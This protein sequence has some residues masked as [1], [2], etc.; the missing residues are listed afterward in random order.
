LALLLIFL[1][2]GQRIEAWLRGLGPWAQVLL[3]L[4]AGLLLFL[5]HPVKDA[6]AAAATFAGLA[7]G[8]AL[9]RRYVPFDPS[10]PVPQRILRFAVGAVVVLALFLGLRA[11]LP[12]EGE[13]A[14]IPFRVLRYGLVGLWTTLGA[15]WLFLRLRLAPQRLPAGSTA[16]P[17]SAS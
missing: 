17:R 13:P 10:G 2:S 15:P 5:F 1:R 11:I 8:L 6:A 4:A 16:P 14:Y 7:A 12:Q 3:A 9:M